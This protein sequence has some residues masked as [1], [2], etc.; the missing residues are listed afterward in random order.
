[1]LNAYIHKRDIIKLLEEIE[2]VNDYY[3]EKVDF[4]KAITFLKKYKKP[5]NN[6]E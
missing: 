5:K 2:A 4:Q 3:I 1:M 6:I